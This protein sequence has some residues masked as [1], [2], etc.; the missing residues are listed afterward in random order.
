MMEAFKNID[1]RLRSWT[2]VPMGSCENLN[3]AILCCQK[4]L[5]CSAS[6]ILLDRDAMCPTTNTTSWME[7]WEKNRKSSVLYKYFLD[8]KAEPSSVFEKDGPCSQLEIHSLLRDF[9]FK[10]SSMPT[11]FAWFDPD[12]DCNKKETDHIVRN[13]NKIEN[14]K[15][16]EYVSGVPK[17]EWRS[18]TMSEL[19]EIAKNIQQGKQG[20]WELID[21]LFNFMA[22]QEILR[23]QPADGVPVVT[24][25]NIVIHNR[26]TRGSMKSFKK[27]YLRHQNIETLKSEC[28][29]KFELD[30]GPG[31]CLTWEGRVLPCD[32]KMTLRDLYE[33]ADP[34][35]DVEF[36][37][38]MNFVRN[39]S[40]SDDEDDQ[41]NI[42]LDM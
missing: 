12:H 28:I 16:L 37:L 15:D 3:N 1:N 33:A 23:L 38:M 20:K 34:I 9:S 2:I 27:R 29:Q 32:K 17:A 22:K 10:N 19:V 5:L 4:T 36:G 39:D 35:K 14:G 21:A 6:V 18:K 30:N 25:T 31:Y 8:H 11:L 42:G 13:E 7:A 40:K 24:C 41:N 26:C